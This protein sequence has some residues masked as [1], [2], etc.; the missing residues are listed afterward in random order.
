MSHDRRRTIAVDF[1]GVIH[2]YSR[3]SSGRPIYDP[4]VEGAREALARIHVRYK[5]VIF[6]TRVNPQMPGAESQMNNVLAWLDRHG[7]R[8]G[9][10]FD[11]IT[12]VKPPALAYIDDRAI[13]F[14]DWDPTLNELGQLYHLP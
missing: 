13:Q 4:P 7:F 11:E 2:R 12:H 9:E 10:H 1:D 5:V 14:T 8:T 3:G 6:T